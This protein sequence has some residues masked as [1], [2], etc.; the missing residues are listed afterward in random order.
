[1]GSKTGVGEVK[2]QRGL[3]SRRRERL[4]PSA[5]LLRSILLFDL[6]THRS[7]PQTPLVPTGHV[8]VRLRKTNSALAGVPTIFSSLPG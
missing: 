2:A 6:K 7:F 1:M 4:C 3:L 5:L 8:G